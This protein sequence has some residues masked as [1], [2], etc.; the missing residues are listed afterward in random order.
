ME[1]IHFAV[2]M[3]LK[4]I[5]ERNMTNKFIIRHLIFGWSGVNAIAYFEFIYVD[6]QSTSP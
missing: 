2:R 3:I 1:A 5:P 4:K 6:D